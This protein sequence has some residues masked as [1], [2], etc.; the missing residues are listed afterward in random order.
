MLAGAVTTGVEDMAKKKPADVLAAEEMKAAKHA[1]WKASEQEAKRL[2]Q[3]YNAACLA[4]RKAQE[5]ADAALPQ[6][7]MVRV[8][9][10]SGNEESI[11]SVVIER[12]TPGGVL[13]TRRVGEP[14]GVEYRFKFWPHSGKY[15][16]AEK[17]YGFANDRREL[18]DVPPE[19]MPANCEF[20]GRR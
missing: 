13:V 8:M 10:R 7:R 11:G 4:L 9:W 14:E 18:R 5:Q 3:E 15:A 2:E 17:Q 1:E 12:K 16:Q 6:C 19:F 20:T